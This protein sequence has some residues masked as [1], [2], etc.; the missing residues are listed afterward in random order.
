MTDMWDHRWIG[1]R[2]E[3]NNTGELS[4]ITEAM[5]RLLQEAADNGVEPIM[6]RY[7]SEY[8]ANSAM[9]RWA[10]MCN[11]ELADEAKRVVG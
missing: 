6:L 4:A 1:A 5:L 9:G 7:D 2:D 10:P 8:A 11:K 3:T